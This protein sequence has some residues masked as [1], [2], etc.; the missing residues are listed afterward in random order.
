M[1]KNKFSLDFGGFMDY[2]RVIDERLGTKALQDAATEALDKSAMQ[3]NINI[4]LAMEK[5]PYSFKS[6]QHYSK[7]KAKKSLAETAKKGVEVN[8]TQITA[9]AGVDLSE[10]PEVII[11]A[12]GTPHLKADTN[13]KNAVKCKGKYRKQVMQIQQQV[14]FDKVQGA[15]K[16]G[17][18]LGDILGE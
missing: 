6:G 3:A 12:S 10:A 15:A 11:L 2:A 13:L 16:A 17:E 8:G 7:G 4:S 1:A 18:T 9:Y 5:S 14:F